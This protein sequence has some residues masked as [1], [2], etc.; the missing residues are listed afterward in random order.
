MVSYTIARKR[1]LGTPPKHIETEDLVD[2]FVYAFELS[3]ACPVFEKSRH[4]IK[5]IF[6]KK[7]DSLLAEHNLP[8]EKQWW[9]LMLSALSDIAENKDFFYAKET[10][11]RLFKRIE[12][13]SC[14]QLEEYINDIN[15]A[16]SGETSNYLALRPMAMESLASDMIEEDSGLKFFLDNKN[17]F[18]TILTSNLIQ[19]DIEKEYLSQFFL[20]DDKAIRKYANIWDMVFELYIGHFLSMCYTKEDVNTNESGFEDFVKQTN[21]AFFSNLVKNKLKIEKLNNELTSVILPC[22]EGLLYLQ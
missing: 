11:S 15:I 16:F 6:K 17:R 10:I 13:I 4:E 14:E 21:I 5:S 2:Y 9:A 12:H 20:L 1:L 18:I 7:L 8:I 22:I 19:K 3:W